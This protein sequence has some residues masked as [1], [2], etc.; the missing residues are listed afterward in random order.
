MYALVQILGKQYKAE[1]G[2]RL[3]VDKL[4]KAEGEEVRFESVLLTSD[5][6]K[7]NVG[8]P[9]VPG[10]AVKAV[11]EGHGKAK[12]ILVVKFKRRKDYHKKTGHRQ[13]FTVIRVE[14]IE[15]AQAG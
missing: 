14:A 2:S 9:F 4:A 1:A 8:T 5:A 15:G 7:V 6:G 11:V 3:K 10:A 12:K 13:P